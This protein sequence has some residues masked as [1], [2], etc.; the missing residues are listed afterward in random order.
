MSIETKI[1][2]GVFLAPLT[3]YK[4][5]G[6]AEFF[7]EVHDKLELHEACDWA[8]NRGKEI[9]IL[10]GG[11][12]VLISD[13]GIHGLVI[14]LMN[15]NIILRGERLECGAGASLSRALY[16]AA[17][18]NLTGLEWSAGIPNAT[19]GGSIRGNAGAFG[20]SIADITENVEVF[21]LDKLIFKI[22]SNKDCGFAYKKSSFAGNSR[23][24]VW[25][26]ILKMRKGDSDKI[27]SEI[28]KNIEFRKNKQPNLPSAGSVFKNINFEDLEK[29]NQKLAE[30]AVSSGVAQSGKVGAGWIIEKA[31]LKGK[32]IG[33]AK[34]SLEHANFVVNTGGA[35]AEDIFKLIN[36][37]KNQV[38]INLGV[39]LEIEI[40]LFGF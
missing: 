18:N 15:S 40:Q 33:Q 36:I 24:L 30:E 28:Q 3:T 4:V 21:D 19:I 10:G 13:E 9:V 5:G 11:S 35:K 16:L 22:F 1:R 26:V 2:Q 6:Q 20:V 17:G 37:I 38:R 23:L 8:K 27:K 29:I 31:G 7:L 25:E 34:V 32:K 39:E 14:K 12:N